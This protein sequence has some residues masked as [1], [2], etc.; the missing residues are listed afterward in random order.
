MTAKKV[1]GALIL[2]T[3][4]VASFVMYGETYGYL[5]T[6][7]IYAITFT[8]VTLI[9]LAVNLLTSEDKEDTNE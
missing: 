3:L 6:I 8:I 7:M 5:L 2:V 1:L 9:V 4:F